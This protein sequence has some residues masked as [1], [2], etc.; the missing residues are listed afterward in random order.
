MKSERED[1][2]K[3]RKD[4]FERRWLAEQVA[5]GKIMCGEKKLE[6]LK[7]EFPR[8]FNQYGLTPSEVIVKDINKN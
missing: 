1:R 7:K 6:E 2:E 5:K 3:V 4:Y 8:K